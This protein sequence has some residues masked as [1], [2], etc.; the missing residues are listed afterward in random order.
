[1]HRA[2]HEWERRAWEQ[3]RAGEPGPALAPYRAHDRLHIHDTRAEAAE[4]MVAGWDETRRNLPGGQAVMITDASNNER[5]RI[6]A[7]AQQRRA[8]A[9]ELGSDRVELPGKPYGLRRRR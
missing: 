1:M 9:G 7:M 6:N 4:A 3:V 2:H 5:D 8:E